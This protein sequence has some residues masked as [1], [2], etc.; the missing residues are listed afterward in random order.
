MDSKH[1]VQR[2]DDDAL[3]SAL[4]DYAET[5]TNNRFKAHGERDAVTEASDGK[6]RSVSDCGGSRAASPGQRTNRFVDR[7]GRLA[8]AAA[9]VV[10]LGTFAAWRSETVSRIATDQTNP[11]TNNE[12]S[13]PDGDGSA[14][15]EKDDEGSLS[16]AAD[17]ETALLPDPATWRP[18]ESH[19]SDPVLGIE[20]Y[21]GEHEADN[22]WGWRRGGHVFV[23]IEGYEAATQPLRSAFVE[24]DP[25]RLTL[26]WITEGSA[27]ALQSYDSTEEELRQVA[28]L[29]TPTGDG[30]ELPGA[31][32]L[33]RSERARTVGA[34][35]VV[36]LEL[37][38]VTDGV[39]ALRSTATMVRYPGDRAD[40]LA[41]LF[42]ASSIGP[43]TETNVAGSTAF[44]M[45]GDEVAYALSWHDGSVYNWISTEGIDMAD[46]LATIDQVPSD[47]WLAAAAQAPVNRDAALEAEVSKAAAAVEASPAAKEPHLPR[48][49][50]PD[51]WTPVWI[52]DMGAWTPEQRAQRNALEQAYQPPGPETP[53]VREQAFGQP[54]PT[55]S[56]AVP[57]VR[58]EI[59]RI[60]S[61]PDS[62]A[63][64][65]STAR[66]S[67]DDGIPIE[68][69][70]L[71]GTIEDNYAGGGNSAFAYGQGFTI[72]ISSGTLDTADF[73]DFVTSLSFDSDQPDRLVS[74]HPSLTLMADIHYP[75]GAP[76]LRYRRWLGQWIDEEGQ[77]LGV[78]VEHLPPAKL[79][80]ERTPWPGQQRRPP[81]YELRGQYVLAQSPYSTVTV[82]RYDEQSSTG[83]TLDSDYL[84]ANELIKLVES[85]TEVDLETWIE[86]IAPYNSDPANPR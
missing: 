25:Q 40:M 41:E 30:W 71:P 63:S 46:F 36:Q 79:V 58:V 23:L 14:D 2:G 26:A 51:G 29:L 8:L 27:L 34:A 10:L 5:L 80:L 50:L 76:D 1:G 28:S 60:E 13:I 66:Q 78:S 42:Q 39:A 6:A 53:L 16:R 43:V 65:E 37:A 19:E 49:M 3:T 83:I 45:H 33:H 74:S 20:D 9:A 69:A 72:A 52:T 82:T 32:P 73:H 59:G 4:F 17:N 85:L 11:A 21:A 81:T 15:G 35:P 77:Q 84:T 67:P 18:I 48:L 55:V 68:I 47:T 64:A 12:V 44:I 57:D 38:A 31:E 56:V 7:G 62:A 70:G 75:D 86:F 61:P 22:A 54:D 24:E